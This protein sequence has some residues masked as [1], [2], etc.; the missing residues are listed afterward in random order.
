[1]EKK[2]FYIAIEGKRRMETQSSGTRFLTY[3]G[4]E[5]MMRGA[6][7]EETWK[8]LKALFYKSRT[9]GD[10]SRPEGKDL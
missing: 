6:K 1:M 10:L 3:K 9:W 4:Y 2:I 5:E 7:K 8:R